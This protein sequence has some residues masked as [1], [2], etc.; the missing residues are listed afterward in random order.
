MAAAKKPNENG[1]GTL[2]TIVTDR[3]LKIYEAA[4]KT[5]ASLILMFDAPPQLGRS[6]CPTNC[7]GHRFKYDRLNLRL[8]DVLYRAKINPMGEGRRGS[9]SGCAQRHCCAATLALLC[10]SAGADAFA[11]STP[12]QSTSAPGTPT[13]P[14]GST[15]ERPQS[16]GQRLPGAQPVS[17]PPANL[18]VAAPPP[19]APPVSAPNAPRFVLRKVNIVGNT[20]IDQAAINRVV[21]PYIGKVVTPADLEEIRRRF[22]RLY[23]DRGFINSGA[24]LPDQT[25]VNGV[26]T[27]R[28]VEG[29][30]TD[31]N[32]A[33]TQHFKSEYFS[34]RLARA[35]E[36]PF[37][38]VD[39]EEEQQILLQDPLIRRLNV[40]ILPG[41]VP[42]EARLDADV[43]EASR[44]SLFAQV[45]D[46]QSPTVGETRGQLQGSL[47]NIVGVGDLLT[48][49]YG[50]SG[51][52][53][54]G[55]IG[56]SV[57]I[58]SDDT[59]F[60]LRYDRNGTVVVTPALVP[61]NVTS[62]YSSVG[63]GLSRPF[64]RTAEQN[65]T[66]AVSLERREEETFLLGMP[67]DFV[68]GSKNGYTN[69]T[70]LRFSQSWLDRNA[71]HALALRSTFS[72]GLGAFGATTVDT[73][74]PSSRFFV[75]L[76]Q[77]QYVQRIWN[78]IEGLVRADLQLSDRPLFQIEQFALGGIDT[79]RG[80]REYLTVTDDAV[81]ASAELHVPVGK[82][83]LPYL[84]R[85][86][87]DG[88]VQLVP[89]YDY[90]QGWNVGR[91]TPFPPN[92]SG[93]GAGLRWYL[94]AGLTAE[95]YY[96]YGI[97]HVREVTGGNS[98]ED[99]GI[100]FRITSVFF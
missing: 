59:R 48:A 60:S 25:I 57:P 30:I 90:G 53:N 95:F 29:R 75:W 5:N 42:G 34:S 13:A 81:L 50:R 24:V 64:Y 69:V 67:F 97:R 19:S 17:P 45:A 22:T 28:F 72:L 62:S 70:A 82:I 6:R 27:Y 9:A 21:T 55:F 1:Q 58:A 54:D 73:T 32:I 16:G 2:I 65:L 94:G 66:L 92:I 38:V 37:N 4:I 98:L 10:L 61:L 44:Y 18:G 36:A 47:A 49:N 88:I 52:L 89:F 39:L 15:G 7:A 3:V 12:A 20:V 43:S 63:V 46:D 74:L 76:G 33:G 93:V 79:V 68:P 80:Y 83:R 91:P 99:K 26:V 84:A 40:E 78:D 8:A 35:T 23:I 14:L 56:Y 11:Q 86:D 71:D 77:G 85:T 87:T 31:I 96:G 51:A 100:Y 41:L